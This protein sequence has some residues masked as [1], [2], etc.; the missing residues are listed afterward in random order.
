M[1]TARPVSVRLVKEIMI[2]K[3]TV[4]TAEM[5]LWQV[6]ELFISKGYSGAPVVDGMHRVI[7]IL[8]EGMVMRLAASEGLDATIAHCLP[9]MPTLDA[10]IKV[11]PDDTFTHAY[12]LFLK[13]NIHRLPVVDANGKLLGLISRGTILKIFVEAHYGKAIPTRK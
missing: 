6:A 7:S 5:K 10:M 11:G 3:V 12:K 2:E 4:V 8:G 13:H 9:K 1:N